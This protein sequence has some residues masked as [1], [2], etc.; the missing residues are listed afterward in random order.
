[1]LSDYLSEG[2]FSERFKIPHQNKKSYPFD[3]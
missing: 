3:K 1:M 2:K